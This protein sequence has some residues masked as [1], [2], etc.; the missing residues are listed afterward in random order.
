MAYVEL[1]RATTQQIASRTTPSRINFISLAWDWGQMVVW[2]QSSCFIIPTSLVH[3]QQSG[4]DK[5]NGSCVFRG[6][7]DEV[8]VRTDH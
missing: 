8:A 4:N 5:R 2:V 3:Q 7:S 1:T 6:P